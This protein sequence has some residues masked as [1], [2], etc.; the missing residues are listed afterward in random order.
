ML[1][2]IGKGTWGQSSPVISL[3]HNVSISIK[4]CKASLVPVGLHFVSGVLMN[5]Q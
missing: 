2:M 1:E 5:T 3:P 4:F